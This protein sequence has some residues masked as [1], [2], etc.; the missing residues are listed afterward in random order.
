MNKKKARI[1]RLI[2]KFPAELLT[3]LRTRT[4]VITETRLA[5]R[6]ELHKIRN[7]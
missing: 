3:N 5:I 4:V 6:K 1:N 7:D 2:T